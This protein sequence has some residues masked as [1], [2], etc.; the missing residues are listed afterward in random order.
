MLQCL[1]AKIGLRSRASQVG[2]GLGI[3]GEGGQRKGGFIGDKYQGEYLFLDLK[4]KQL[5]YLQ[6]IFSK[7]IFILIIFA[8]KI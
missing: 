3:V 5:I 7:S 8:Y 4:C 2:K 1:D 6:C